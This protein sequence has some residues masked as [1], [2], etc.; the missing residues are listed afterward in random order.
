MNPAR[1]SA[2]LY[3]TACLALVGCSDDPAPT[4][5]D[6]GAETGSPTDGAVDTGAI[7]TGTSDTGGDTSAGDATDAEASRTISFEARVGS[8]VFDCKKSFD[9][10]GTNKDTIRPLDFRLYVHDVRLVRADGTEEAFVLD[11]DGLFQ[12][13]GV[14]LLD[15]EDKSGTCT[16]GTAE[17]HTT[18]S[19][20]VK[21][22]TYTGVHFTLG[23]PFAQNHQDQTKAGS[24]LN[25]SALFWSWNAG[26]KFARLDV[27]LT[28]GT[29]ADA[30]ADAATGTDFVFHLGS[31]GCVGDAK[32]GGVTSCSNPNRGDV[33]IT[34]FDPFAKKILVDYAA[35]VATTDL[36]HDKGGMPGCMSGPTDPECAALLAAAGVDP[37]TGAGKAS[38]QKLFRVE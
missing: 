10:V 28:P 15:F 8:A 35:L 12:S 25:L 24:P 22:G 2:A 11:D 38:T 1:R 26:Y 17:L 37:A 19:G 36:A 5:D 29:G 9:G 6:A 18:L 14:A 13:K 20:K 31:T 16:N 27:S 4:T 23:V 30:G 7:D 34:G 3:L 21:A 32:D 33:K